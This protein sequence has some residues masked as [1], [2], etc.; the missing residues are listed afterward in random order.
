MGIL[1]LALSWGAAYFSLCI[2][3]LSTYTT[4]KPQYKIP[5]IIDIPQ[6]KI[7]CVEEAA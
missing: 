7:R 5:P 4:P 2:Q 6:F 3:H 1:R